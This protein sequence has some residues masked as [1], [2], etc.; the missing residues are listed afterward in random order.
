MQF[1]TTLARRG[2]AAFLFLLIPA[3]MATVRAEPADLDDPAV[4]EAFVDGL[5][6]PLMKSNKFSMPSTAAMCIAV[7]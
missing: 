2:G 7:G 3:L 1:V 4:V 5:V 6:K